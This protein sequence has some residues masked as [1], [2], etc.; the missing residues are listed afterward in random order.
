MHLPVFECRRFLEFL[1]YTERWTEERRRL[2]NCHYQNLK[3]LIFQTDSITSLKRNDRLVG[4]EATLG[5]RG[6]ARR[7][8]EGKKETEGQ[9]GGRGRERES[10]N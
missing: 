7:R 1:K 6:R 4:I 3:L 2:C 8:A 5:S 9:G 10:K